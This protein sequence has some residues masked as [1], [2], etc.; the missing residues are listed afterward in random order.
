MGGYVASWYEHSHLDTYLVYRA[1]VGAFM[2]IPCGLKS[3]ARFTGLSPVE[4]DRERIHELTTEE[5]HAY[6]A[7]DAIMTRELTLRRWNTAKRSI[8]TL[9]AVAMP[10]SA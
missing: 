5:L 7:S 3:L 1:D 10:A 8:D 2:H 9:P 4:V 6:V